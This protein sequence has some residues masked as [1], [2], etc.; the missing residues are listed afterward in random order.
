MPCCEMDVLGTTLCQWTGVD[1]WNAL[2]ILRYSETSDDEWLVIIFMVLQEDPTNWERY[3]E[4]VRLNST[5]STVTHDNS[6]RPN[7]FLGGA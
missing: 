2:T 3:D 6:C 5:S 7:P 1:D 4:T